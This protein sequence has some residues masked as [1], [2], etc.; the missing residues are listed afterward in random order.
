MGTQAS[1]DVCVYHEQDPT[2]YIGVYKSKNRDYI[3]IYSSATTSSEE[4]FIKASEPF[5]EF[6]VFQKRRKD[7]FIQRGAAGRQIFNHD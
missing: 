4:R 7:V 6:Q 2:N 5:S 3:L 1:E